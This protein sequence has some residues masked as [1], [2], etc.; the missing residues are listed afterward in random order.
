MITATQLITR[1]KT[2]NNPIKIHWDNPSILR[3][4]NTKFYTITLADQATPL[5]V[6]FTGEVH[7]GK[8]KPLNQRNDWPV[9]L[10]IFRDRTGIRTYS[11]LFYALSA[12]KDVFLKEVHDRVSQRLMKPQNTYTPFQYENKQGKFDNPLM[13]LRIDFGKTEFGEKDT[14]SKKLVELN[15]TKENIHKYIHSFSSHSG[16]VRLSVCEHN[17][18]ITLRAVVLIDVIANET[19]TPTLN[20]FH[21]EERVVWQQN[22]EDRSYFDE[23]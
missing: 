22:G 2:E 21:I 6:K 14:E 23:Q 1:F 3:G 7:K 5:Q 10:Q 17:M 19:Y 18:G 20:N 12:V 4:T 13:R 16:V 15:V 8:I 11:D 9:S